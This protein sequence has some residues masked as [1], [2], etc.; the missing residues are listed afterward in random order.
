MNAGGDVPA[1]IPSGEIPQRVG[2][3][4]RARGDLETMVQP[5]LDKLAERWA[6][7]FP[8]LTP[9]Q[10]LAKVEKRDIAEIIARRFKRADLLALPEVQNVILEGDPIRQNVRA[11]LEAAALGE[12]LEAER[13]QANTDHATA[14]NQRAKEQVDAKTTV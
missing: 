12:M 8:N 3:Q 5:Y 9:A 14:D 11:D 13:E 7:R 4:A 10:I 6:D 1:H 2:L